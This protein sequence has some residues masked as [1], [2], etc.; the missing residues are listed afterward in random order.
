MNMLTFDPIR[1]MNHDILRALQYFTIPPK[2]YRKGEAVVGLA[3]ARE[4]KG[5][6]L[7]RRKATS[8]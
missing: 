6:E 1:A 5:R 4:T 3:R 7:G 8:E 2:L